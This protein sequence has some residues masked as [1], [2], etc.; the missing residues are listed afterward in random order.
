VLHAVSLLVTYA[1]LQMLLIVNAGR[2]GGSLTLT[3]DCLTTEDTLPYIPH[4][5]TRTA[6]KVHILLYF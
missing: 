1:Y 3:T 5:T 6:D 4:V 2:S